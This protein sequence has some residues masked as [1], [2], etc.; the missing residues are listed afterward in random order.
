MK[1]PVIERLHGL[2]DPGRSG[3]HHVGNSTHWIVLEGV[4]ILTDPWISEPADHLLVHS[5]PPIPFPTAPDVVLLTHRH[6]DHFDPEALRRL[7]RSATVVVPD[8]KLASAVR[9][10]GFE[11]VRSARAGERLE[12]VRGLSI[13]VVRG[14]HN[15]PLVCYRVERNGRAFFFGADTM[16]TPEIE[17]LATKCPVEVAILPGERSSLLGRRFVMTP[18]EAIALAQRMGASRAVLSHHEHQVALRSP[19][20]WLVRIEPVSRQEFPT[21]FIV[22]SPGDFVPFPWDEAAAL[23]DAVQRKVVA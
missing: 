1:R 20:R 4:S 23:P 18:E 10:L 19:W 2:S 22:P 8:G 14:R 6:D 7:E 5:V 11:D 12:D 17:Q 3:L 15:V 13:D 16:L 9:E 21:W